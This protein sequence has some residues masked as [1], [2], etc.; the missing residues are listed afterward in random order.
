V[1]EPFSQWVLEDHFP[2]G[3]PAWGDVGVELVDDVSTHEAV[4]LRV[5]NGG[6]SALAYLGLLCGH[7]RID[8]AATDP[9]LAGFV[10]AF[11]AD[12]VL[13]A[14][15]CPPGWDLAAYAETTMSRFANSAITYPASKVA[16]D[17]SQKLPVR[18]MPTVRDRLSGGG[19]APLSAIVVAAWATVTRGPRA[20]GLEGADEALDRW[21]RSA[22]GPDA[23]AARSEVERLLGMPGFELGDEPSRASFVDDVVATAERLWAGDVRSVLSEAIGAGERR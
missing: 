5:L 18:L 13:P 8:D 2:S 12:E 21:L 22:G 6:H 7:L 14:L 10:S 16:G 15:V 9:V 1:T 4:K 20:H 17:G 19:S 23:G 11:W 3:R